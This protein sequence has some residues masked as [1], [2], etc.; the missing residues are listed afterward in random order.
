MWTLFCVVKLLDHIYFKN[1][2]CIFI[3]SLVVVVGVLGTVVMGQTDD[4]NCPDLH[5]G[6]YPHLYRWDYLISRPGNHIQYV[7]W[8]H[9]PWHWL[10][11][12]VL[13][14][15]DKYWY[16]QE[17]RSELRTCGNGLGFIDTDPTYTL[18]QCNELHLV[19]CGDRTELEPPISTPH[20]PRAWGTFED[21]V[22]STLLRIVRF[23]SF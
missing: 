15:C 12:S 9:C 4:F 20:C 7:S 10:L 18:E 5:I 17:G 2:Y 3:F 22:S 21:E 11:Y 23:W 6:F 16:C 8:H 14:S 13:T 19:E 1:I